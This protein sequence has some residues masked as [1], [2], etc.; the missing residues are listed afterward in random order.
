[1][2][3]NL[4][5]F[6]DVAIAITV[7]YLAYLLLFSK[8]KMFLF[9]RIYLIT[10]ILI[11]FIIPLITFSEKIIMPNILQT[12]HE[13]ASIMPDVSPRQTLYSIIWQKLPEALFITGFITF[14]AILIAGH[15]KARIIIKKSSKQ[16]L[17]GHSVLISHEDIPPFTYFDKLIIPSKITNTPHIQSVIH[18]ENIHK[19]EW[20]CIDLL[21]M[22]IMFL[23][24]WFNPFAW[25]IKKAVRDNLEYLTDDKV[26]G[27]IDKQEYQLGII[28]LAGKT[29]FYTLPSL[30]N[31]SQLKKRIIMM[32]KN[33][34]SKC[35]WIRTLVIIPILAFMT[36]TLSGREVEIISTDK[37]IETK[38]FVLRSLNDSLGSPMVIVDG[39]IL[40]I[41]ELNK[42]DPQDIHSISILKD[43]SAFEVYGEEGMN[44]VI[45]VTT[46]NEADKQNFT[47]NMPNNTI[48]QNTIDLKPQSDSLIFKLRIGNE[49]INS[50]MVIIDGE[51]YSYEEFNIRNIDPQNI[52]SISVLKDSS[53]IRIYGEEGK[54]G[55]IIIETKK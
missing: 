35:V 44:G 40:T 16:S 46:K 29:S 47:A 38:A 55:V 49:T 51:K 48:T 25:L 21:L 20:H 12:V 4:P 30:S 3:I 36:A 42:F 19:K 43:N 6:I 22:E 32:T 39:K 50:P 45:I 15:I 28:S 13:S 27:F 52:E 9:N 10:S 54:N 41:D 1:M 18:H 17:Y 5:Y 34:Q 8:E 14:L 33:K 37:I 26:A 24:Q 23:F 2:N 53:A 11:S 31:Q 7:F